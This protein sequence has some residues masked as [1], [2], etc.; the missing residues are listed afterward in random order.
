MAEIKSEMSGTITKV[1]VKVGDSVEEDQD[2]IG[3]ESMKMEMFIASEDEGN[4]ETIHVAEG[5][6]VNEGDLL[7]TLK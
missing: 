6:F 2:V 3:M 5:D 7:I 4:V 1:L